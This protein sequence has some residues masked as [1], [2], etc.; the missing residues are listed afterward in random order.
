MFAHDAPLANLDRR[1][2]AR[3]AFGA[4]PSVQMAT[5][6]EK[7]GMELLVG[8]DDPVLLLLGGLMIRCASQAREL[9]ERAA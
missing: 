3:I 1:L 5:V 2:G 4:P 7:I 9:A 6:L 8:E